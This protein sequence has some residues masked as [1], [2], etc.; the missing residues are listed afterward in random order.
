MQSQITFQTHLIFTCQRYTNNQLGAW[1]LNCI[2][3]LNTSIKSIFCSL[4]LILYLSVN[5]YTND[6]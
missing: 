5:I 6:L 3:L 4:Y 1:I 2:Q